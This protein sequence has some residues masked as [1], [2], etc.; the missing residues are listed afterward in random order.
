MGHANIDVTADLQDPDCPKHPP[1]SGFYVYMLAVAAAMGGFLLGYDSG[2]VSAAMLYVPDVSEMKPMS[3]VWKEMIVAIIPAWAGI[4][5]LIAGRVSEKFGRK[6][7]VLVTSFMFTIGALICSAA[8]NKIM[9][10][11]GRV[12]IGFATGFATTIAPVYIAEVSN[13]NVRGRLLLMLQ[14]MWAIG[15][16]L[17][18]LIGASFSYVD[19]YNVGWRLM[20]GFAAIPSFVQFIGF[21]FLPDS[22]KW[23]YKNRRES[24][25]FQVLQDVYCQ[26]KEWVTYEFEKIKRDNAR[27]KE[28]QNTFD[29][30][31][32]I[33]RTPHI[34]KALLIGCALQIF[35]QLCGATMVNYYIGTIIKSA[36]VTNN[37]LS[38]WLSFSVTLPNLLITS[39]SS[40]FIDRFGRRPLLLVS[41]TL[42]LIALLFVSGSFLLINKE[43]ASVIRL[44]D[45]MNGSTYNST[46]EYF[47]RCNAY[48][49]CDYCVED[50]NCGFCAQT[51]EVKHSGY[52]FP[53][54][55]HHA[56]TQSS[57]GFC[58]SPTS[59]NT[60]FTHFYN[61]TT[62]EWMN[63]YC[64]TDFTALPI[65][66]M[67]IFECCF[68]SGL[69]SMPWVLNG[70]FYPFWARSTCVSIAI[71]SYWMFNLLV[72]LTFL[73]LN[74]TIT[75]FG[76]FFIYAGCTFIGLIFFIFFVPETKGKSLEDVENLFKKKK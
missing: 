26:D 61:G 23:L 6:K 10:L 75:K 3:T 39:S 38:I 59:S 64:K 20:F 72:S 74:E 36:G 1:K 11:V 65:V 53:V 56:E 76:T 66:L 7:S 24:E 5:A 71:F 73:S 70:E 21:L 67:I 42:T 50:S 51:S 54:M 30:I 35:S 31:W 25:C 34:R 48:K 63:S 15:L 55:D 4:G 57:T 47:H 16:K 19:P 9:L 62:Y 33:L 46:Y 18:N 22:P 45:S 28:E 60:N 17:S 2:I 37:H 8:L 49:N 69:S 12:L 43:S 44:G 14:I 68:A 29:T 27:T 32:R 52:C 41:T 13:A 40:F 58:S